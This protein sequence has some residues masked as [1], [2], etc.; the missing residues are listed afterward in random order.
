MWWTRSGC[1]SIGHGVVIKAVGVSLLYVNVIDMVVSV[2]ISGES[3]VVPVDV[4]VWIWE[5]QR[6]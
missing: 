2:C 6:K 3:V 1:K 5:A 4:K